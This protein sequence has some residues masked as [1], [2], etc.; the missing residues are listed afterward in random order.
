MIAV[1]G[2][3]QS[4][5]PAEWSSRGHWVDISTM[6]EGVRSTYVEGEEHPLIDPQPDKFPRDPWAVWSGTS[7]AAPQ[8]AGAVAEVAQRQ[9]VSPRAAL[10]RLLAGGREVPNY[11]RAVRILPRT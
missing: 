1:G 3:T 10:D 4:L 7:F 2:L 9:G 6:A 8:V 5:E 11:G